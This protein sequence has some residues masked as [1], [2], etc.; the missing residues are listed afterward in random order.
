MTE[1]SARPAVSIVPRWLSGGKSESAQFLRGA[2]LR[3]GEPGARPRRSRGIFNER[4]WQ[5]RCPYLAYD[6]Q[7]KESSCDGARQAGRS[8]GRARPSG[9]TQCQA[10]KTDCAHRGRSAVASRAR[11]VADQTLPALLRDAA[12]GVTSCSLMANSASSTRLATPSFEKILV[13]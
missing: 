9:E 6:A 12:A 11:C 1:S 7:T 8:V 13:R 10:A 3:E 5:R 4:A 2:A